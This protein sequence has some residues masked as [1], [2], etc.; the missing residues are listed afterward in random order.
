MVGNCPNRIESFDGSGIVS[1]SAVV[2][3]SAD[4]TEVTA[5]TTGE[6]CGTLPVQSCR[7]AIPFESS[8]EARILDASERCERNHGRKATGNWGGQSESR[9]VSPG[10][11]HL[12]RC[13]TV[14]GALGRQ[15]LPVSLE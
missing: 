15:P 5:Q 11:L 1:G 8:S 6:L 12:R 3:V 7:Q 10:R 13:G 4:P 14:P 2:H 9:S